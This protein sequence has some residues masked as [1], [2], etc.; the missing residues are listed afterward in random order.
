MIQNY[1]HTFYNINFILSSFIG[2]L[3]I[4]FGE[5]LLQEPA[6]EVDSAQNE[7][8]MPTAASVPL[9]MRILFEEADRVSD[10]EALPQ[11]GDFHSLA[12][13]VR[14]AK[15]RQCEYFCFPKYFS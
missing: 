10:Q 6:F 3:A 13:S 5:F 4:P 14:P 11:G 7:G 2:K 12:R 1:Q 9:V 8:E 15:I